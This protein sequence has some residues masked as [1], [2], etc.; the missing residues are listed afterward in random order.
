MLRHTMSTQ[1]QAQHPYLTTCSSQVH[2]LVPGACC[3]TS[4]SLATVYIT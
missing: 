1:A 4:A 2:T 3:G